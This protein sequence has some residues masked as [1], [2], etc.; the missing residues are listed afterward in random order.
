MLKRGDKKPMHNKRLVSNT[1]LFA[2]NLKWKTT[3]LTHSGGSTICYTLLT[4]DVSD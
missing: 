3:P 4:V 2:S 1:K